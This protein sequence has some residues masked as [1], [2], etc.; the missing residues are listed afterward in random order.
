MVSSHEWSS[1]IAQTHLCIQ[2]DLMFY[3]QL[4]PQELSKRRELRMVIITLLSCTAQVSPR[5]LQEHFVQ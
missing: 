2:N 1:I 3:L 4:K 5:S